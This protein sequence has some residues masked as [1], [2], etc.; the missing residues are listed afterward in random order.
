MLN[1][2]QTPRKS[3]NDKKKAAMADLIL[4]NPNPN[5]LTTKKLWILLNFNGVVTGYNYPSCR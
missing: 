1:E 3:M 4:A 2:N 5:P